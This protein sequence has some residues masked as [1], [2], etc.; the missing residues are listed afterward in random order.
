MG[1]HKPLE[2]AHSFVHITKSSTKAVDIE[3]PEKQHTHFENW[4]VSYQIDQ[5]KIKR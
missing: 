2:Q 4:R 1:L 3:I 5:G